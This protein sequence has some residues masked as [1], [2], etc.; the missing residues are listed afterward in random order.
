ML[1]FDKIRKHVTRS[2]RRL[3]VDKD[4]QYVLRLIGESPPPFRLVE[5]RG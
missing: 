4:S 1:D 2:G 5:I 3:G